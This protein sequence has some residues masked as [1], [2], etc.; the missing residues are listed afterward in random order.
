MKKLLL[1]FGL[2]FAS[3]AFGQIAAGVISS[4]SQRIYVPSHDAVAEQKSMTEERSLLIPSNSVHGQGSRPL[5]ELAPVHVDIP[6]GD[7][8]R[9]LKKQHGAF[10]KADIVWEN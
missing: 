1:V 8:A 5:W 3:Q 9:M 2:F 7:T 4:E 10:R 6:L